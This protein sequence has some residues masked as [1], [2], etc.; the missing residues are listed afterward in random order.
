MR[1][2]SLILENFRGYQEESI[3]NFDQSL[4]GITGKNDSGKS[5]ILEAL[6]IFFNNDTV[7][8][9]SGDLNVKATNN[10]ITI[11][12][13]FDCLPEEVI[14]DEDVPTTFQNEYLTNKN[15]DL[16]IRKV[17]KALAKVAAPS[18]Y[19][20][21]FHPTVENLNNLHSLKIADLKKVGKNLGVEE[22]IEDQRVSSLWRKA[23]WETCEDL[24]QEDTDIDISQFG[25][26]GKSIY[27]KIEALSPTFA[28][29]KA[30]RE[31][32]DVDPEA[33]NPM[34]AAVNQAKKVL[35]SEIDILQAKIETSVLE[36]A[37]RTLEKIKEM[38]PNLANELKPK[39]KDKPK[40]TFN[41]TLDG[42][43]GVPINKRGSGVRRLILLNFFRAEAEKKKQDKNSP[44]VIY[45]IEE[46]ET[47]QHPNYQIM[48][49]QSL[50]D[51]SLRD[52]CQIILTT[53][54]PALAGLIP[55]EGIR[56]INKK[57]S[58]DV[59]IKSGDD[60]VL[61]EAA[62]SLG[63]LPE[64]SVAS[65]KAVVMVEGHSDTTFLHHTSEELKSAGHIPDTIAEKGIAPI[66]I[67]GCG[68]LKHWVT[69]KLVDQLGLEWCV[70]LDSDVGDPVQ[71]GR[72]ITK[73]KE[74]RDLGKK[75]IL[76]RKR[77]PENYIDPSIIKDQYGIEVTY[78]GT[79]DAKKIIGSATK[80]RKADV[81]EKFW[82]HMT[83][84]QMVVC[85]EYDDGEEKRI[86]LVEILTE[87]LGI[88]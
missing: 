3:I 73:I 14:V 85:S 28:L 18:I 13:I 15:N 78:T 61:E 22:S 56:F 70:L 24:K 63:V 9:D 42:D 52:E 17:Y 54:V 39:F 45:A 8:I 80:T 46:P 47:S 43:E 66:P 44:R 34:Q 23:I 19:L 4:T 55:V 38:D 49:M 58:G 87:I 11:G 83:A 59:E 82:P 77:E 60:S 64:S 74:V 12:C 88:I 65:A 5:S 21:A 33:K 16:E 26:E 75:G 62:S 41:F 32:S 1:L 67:G 27:S 40:W 20:R 76:T 35:Q 53:H 30:D 68:N 84:A 51:L 31:S 79:C 86:E 57:D 6:E 10:L 25:K 71:N 81:L 50:I 29:F 7:K 2:K 36:V 48:L 69:K 37:D 72:N